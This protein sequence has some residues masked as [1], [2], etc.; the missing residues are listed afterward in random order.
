MLNDFYTLSNLH[1]ETGSVT[2][3]VSFHAAHEIFK[4]HFPNQPVVPG[5]C[6][7]AVA[8]MV[9]EQ[10]LEKKLRLVS[11]GNVKF[12]RLLMPQDEPEFI[13]NYEQK[14]TGLHTQ[15]SILLDGQAVFKMNG[16]YLVK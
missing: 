16:F 6:T 7:M 10:Q 3:K 15:V 8:K 12:L 11:A 1:S 5:V 9:M 14:E 13:L 2:C 4:G